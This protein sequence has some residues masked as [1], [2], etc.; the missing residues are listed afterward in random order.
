MEEEN[1]TKAMQDLHVF[2]DTST[3]RCDIELQ[4][5]NLKNE[6]TKNQYLSL[7]R[8]DNN[9]WKDI[10]KAQDEGMIPK[11]ARFFH[12]H[13][14]ETA[15]I[16]LMPLMIHQLPH[17][18][19]EDRMREIIARMG[20]SSCSSLSC[21]KSSRFEGK[22][23]SNEPDSCFIPE[24]RN[25]TTDWPSLVFEAGDAESLGRLQ[26]AAKWWLHNSDGEVKTVV[27]VTM[28]RNASRII[29]EKWELGEVDKEVD[30]HGTKKMIPQ[31]IQELFITPD[32]IHGAPLRLKFENVFLRQPVLPE[33]DILFTSSILQKWATRLWGGC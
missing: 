20:M 11:Y 31:K 33:T 4:A 1:T 24:L 15:V 32:T 19:L 8:V 27:L 7:L 28:N 5:D 14:K 12:D 21:L 13:I 9:A 17:L 18:G 2:S 22:S 10:K 29:L 16:K 6:T 23:S 3:L 25:P 30:Q 26:D